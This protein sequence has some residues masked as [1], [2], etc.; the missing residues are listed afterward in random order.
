M[1]CSSGEEEDDEAQRKPSATEGSQG[2]RMQRLRSTRED[3]KLVAKYGSGPLEQ[4]L[5][6]FLIKWVNEGNAVFSD[7]RLE[8][9]EKIGGY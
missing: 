9:E 1:F 6:K 5:G 4:A 3:A 2:E 7:E 8:I